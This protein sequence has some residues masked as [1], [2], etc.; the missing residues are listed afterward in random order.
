M[1]ATANS[2]LN[3]NCPAD[4]V[5]PDLLR[6]AT[7]GVGSPATSVP[8]VL[9]VAAASQ[10]IT[11]AALAGKIFTDIPFALGATASSLLAVSCR[12]QTPL[13]GLP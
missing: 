3:A 7:N 2:L 5:F 6:V 13:E 8:A 12:L 4:P 9:T 10:T 11:F 1:K